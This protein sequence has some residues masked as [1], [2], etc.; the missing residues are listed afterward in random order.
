MRDNKIAS[1]ERLLHILEAI[2]ETQL[3]TKGYSKRTFSKDS[4]LINACL[5]Q[6]T[7]IG[8]AINYIDLEI[9]EKYSYPWHKVRG[10]RNFILHEY[11]AIEF[12][13]VWESIKKDLP[14]LKLAI[15]ELIKKEF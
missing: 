4:V 15:E 6:F 14:E 2:S 8:E 13:I 12:S 1:K 9:L 3:F 11:H 10:F 5:F 7:I